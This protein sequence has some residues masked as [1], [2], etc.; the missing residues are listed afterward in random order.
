MVW[1][2]TGAVLLVIWV[3]FTYITPAGLGIVHLLLAAGVLCV[4][5]GWV[6]LDAAADRAVS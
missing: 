3:F 6:A 2:M 5:R 1:I 4:I